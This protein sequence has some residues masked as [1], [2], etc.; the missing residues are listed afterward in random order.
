MLILRP[1]RLRGEKVYSIRFSHLDKL[2]TSLP[3]TKLSTQSSKRL[4]KALA[5]K[6]SIDMLAFCGRLYY[7]HPIGQQRVAI[8]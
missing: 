4:Q 7:S 2:C 1:R 8:Y 5:H 3:N 6:Y